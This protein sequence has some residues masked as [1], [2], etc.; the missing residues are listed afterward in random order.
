[1]NNYDMYVLWDCMGI[2]P[3]TILEIFL[4]VRI[5]V[6]VPHHDIQIFLWPRKYNIYVHTISMF[7]QYMSHIQY[8]FSG[9][10][11]VP[12]WDLET[13]K[14]F[15]SWLYSFDK[16]SWLCVIQY[17]VWWLI[18]RLL[19]DIRYLQNIPYRNHIDFYFSL[20]IQNMSISQDIF[21]NFV[22]SKHASTWAICICA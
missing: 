17:L 3:I 2:L 20:Q 11:V 12:M 8:V 22:S 7:I 9:S 19:L 21:G 13:S 15:D 1:M 5:T 4:C 14:N 16:W 10:I 18:L 6:P